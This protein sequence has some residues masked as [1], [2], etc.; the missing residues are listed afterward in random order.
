MEYRVVSFAEI[1][2]KVLV[3]VILEHA[4]DQVQTVL[5]QVPAEACA[6]TRA[7]VDWVR[8]LTEHVMQMESSSRVEKMIRQDP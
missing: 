5:G 3:P 8:E 4:P 2:D 1:F 6:T 7:G